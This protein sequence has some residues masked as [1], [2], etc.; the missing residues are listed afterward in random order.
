MEYFESCSSSLKPSHV[1]I[2]FRG[3]EDTRKFMHSFSAALK[4]QGFRIFGDDKRRETPDSYLPQHLHR[5]IRESW[6]W[7]IVFSKNY[8]SSSWCLEELE[9]CTSLGVELTV[10]N[11]RREDPLYD[12]GEEMYEA[13]IDKVDRWRRAMK[14]WLGLPCSRSD[15]VIAVYYDVDPENLLLS[16]LKTTNLIDLAFHF[17]FFSSGPQAIQ[18]I[19]KQVKSRIDQRFY[20]FFGFVGIQSQVEEVEKLLDLSKDDEV[21]VVGICGMVG[22]GKSTIARVLYFKII[23]YFDA[24]CFVPNVSTYLK[25]GGLSLQELL[26]RYL[27]TENSE[28]RD[29]VGQEFLACKMLRNHKFLIVLDGVDLVQD[30]EELNLIEKSDCFGGGS[31]IVLTTRDVKVLQKYEVD[32]IYRPKLLSEDEAFELFCSKAFPKKYPVSD[33]K[34][35]IDRVLEYANGLPLAIEKLGSSFFGKGIAEWRSL[36]DREEIIPP[37]E[38]IMLLRKSFDELDDLNQEMFLD[39][40]C[41]FVGKDINYVKENLYDCISFRVD[42]ELLVQKSLITIANQKIQM[43]RMLQAMGREIIRQRCPNQPDKRSRLYLYS[44]IKHVMEK[45]RNTFK[46]ISLK[47]MGLDEDAPFVYDDFKIM[48]GDFL[49]FISGSTKNVYVYDLIRARGKRLEKI[50]KLEADRYVSII[51]YF[52]TLR[53]CGAGA[54]RFRAH[55]WIRDG[56]G[57]RGTRDIE[58]ERVGGMREYKRHVF[59]SFQFEKFELTGVLDKISFKVEIN[60]IKRITSSDI[61]SASQEA[62]MVLSIILS[63]PIG[64]VCVYESFFYDEVGSYKDIGG[65]VQACCGFHSTFRLT[66]NGWL[67][68]AGKF[69]T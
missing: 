63:H 34:E 60:Y 64:A 41:F 19:V 62:S 24:F 11:Y 47:E 57:G 5:A 38:L 59:N 12:E 67:L 69:F 17:L 28:I 55:R 2:S 56:E 16:F 9:I 21:R 26:R 10:V 65:A 66:Q 53:S 36:L 54:K 7:I 68:N 3:D 35:L 15:K 22:L 20:G 61:E 58:G 14:K 39:I 31:R 33:F 1:Y 42:T 23:H 8:A 52:N 50:G 4:A 37:R 49:V 32:I 18:K 13:N 40:A 25:E 45:E 29:I 51:P 6:I 48:N 44:D 46:S 30:I 43:H 27:E